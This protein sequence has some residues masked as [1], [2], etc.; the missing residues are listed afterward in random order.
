MKYSVFMALIASSVSA[1]DW[2]TNYYCDYEQFVI[3]EKTSTAEDYT[4][5]QCFEWCVNTDKVEG[6]NYDSGED[7]CCD[8]EEW[9]DGSFNCYLYAGGNQIKQ[10]MD[11]YPD[12]IFNS[13]VFPHL[14][15]QNEV[16]EESSHYLAVGAAALVAVAALIWL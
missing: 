4:K 12:D 8:F 14:M 15:P 5:E 13:V 3:E 16:E 9:S 10:D 1:Q 7:M 6:S 2:K 11:D